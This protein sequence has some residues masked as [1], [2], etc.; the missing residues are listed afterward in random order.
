MKVAPFQP[1]SEFSLLGLDIGGTKI[2][3]A[4]VTFA[5][6]APGGDAPRISLEASIPTEA[7][8]GG[9]RVLA[10]IAD[11]AE[12]QI[13]AAS[14]AGMPVSGIA[15]ASAGVVDVETGCI[16]SA[17]DTMPGWGGQPLGPHLAERCGLPVR[18]LNDVHGHALGEATYGAGAGARTALVI[19]VGTGLGGAAV[20]DGRILFGA[21]GVAGH[22][23]H[24]HHPYAAGLV[25]SCGRDG[26]VESVASGSGAARLYA[27]RQA[28]AHVE[29]AS[30]A[31][32]AA[33]SLT[34]IAD[35]PESAYRKAPGAQRP[36]VVRGGRELKA[37]VDAGDM[38]AREVFTDGAF[39]LGQ[40]LGGLA[41]SFDPD[42]IILSGSLIHV[43]EFWMEAL[44]E[45]YRRDAMVGTAATPIVEGSLGSQ[46]PL[47]GAAVHFLHTARRTA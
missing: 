9:A 31:A 18:V 34:G 43:G 26:H 33:A 28:E 21:H 2:A 4:V 10:D 44:R 46:A 17:T 32:A 36:V 41:N 1:G 6:T 12:R 29:G 40:T 23:G 27:K 5:A 8:R 35:V 42:V 39:A 25:C 15:I 20:I 13:A 11:F 47:I 14:A 19:A 16:T 38:F 37:L 22:F 24:I 30:Y 7:R 45:G 3:G